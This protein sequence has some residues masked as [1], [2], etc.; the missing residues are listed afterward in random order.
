VYIRRALE[1]AVLLAAPHSSQLSA[2]WTNY[3]VPGTPRTADGRPD[4]KAPAPRTAG[5]KVDLSGLW[6]PA[7]P[8]PC[9][10][11]NRVCTDLPITRQFGDIGL[12][13][14]D[15]LP[16]SPWAREKMKS[17][18]YKD[19]PYLNCI[20][21]GGPRMHLL[22]TM[23]KIVQTPPLTLIIDEYNTHYRQ[24]FTDGRP[25][26]Q[27]PQP[28]WNGYSVGQWEGDTLVVQSLGYRDDQWLDAAASPLTNSARVTE[29]FRRP[30]FGSL[31]IELTVDDPKAY[32]RPFR[33][34]IKLDQAP[35]TDLLDVVCL[36]NEKDRQ[37]IPDK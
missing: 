21:P 28:T 20:T 32:T 29:R 12:E 14:K 8:L 25:L 13:L 18:G 17:R 9:D 33:V 1:V 30:T 10:G 4:L 31:E 2:Q 35:D 19:D 24:I 22:P 23:K 26:P 34:T 37:H 5:G 16:Y 36:E 15:G 7:N 3:P 27:D 11:F 6:Q